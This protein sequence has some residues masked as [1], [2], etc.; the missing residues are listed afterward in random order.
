MCFV[1]KYVNR[2]FVEGLHRCVLVIIHSFAKYCIVVFYTEHNCNMP[3]YI[4][5]VYVFSY[6]LF[7]WFIVYYS[8]TVFLQ[9]KF[10]P[11]PKLALIIAEAQNVALF[12]YFI[13]QDVPT[14]NLF[15]F[16]FN[17]VL[18]KMIPIYLLWNTRIH[19]SDILWIF[20]V[21]IVYLLVGYFFYGGMGFVE[22]QTKL[23]KG[24]MAKDGRNL[25]KTYWQHKVEGVLDSIGWRV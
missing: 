10:V 7:V 12:A 8:T 1:V 19:E 5:R 6:W 23:V 2:L 18:F 9:I 11:N 3:E 4:S 16:A 14:R 17:N 13:M 25:P 20:L 24:Y 15:I 21:Y 22:M